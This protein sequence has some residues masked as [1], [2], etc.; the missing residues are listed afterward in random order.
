MNTDHD[1]FGAAIL[2]E[3]AA[4]SWYQWNPEPPVRTSATKG[5]L[6]MPTNNDST[7]IIIMAGV[8]SC[9]LATF[10][11]CTPWPDPQSPDVQA[12]QAAARHVLKL[13]DLELQPMPAK[14]APP[15]DLVT[16][17]PVLLWPPV[18]RLGR[19]ISTTLTEVYRENFYHVHENCVVPRPGDPTTGVLLESE[20]NLVLHEAYWNEESL[21][22]R[23]KFSIHHAPDERFWLNHS[24]VLPGEEIQ[25]VIDTATRARGND[26]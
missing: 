24:Q 14:P 3:L 8:H 25:R 15:S 1:P 7:N 18:D 20:D 4:S 26:P 23:M 22:W 2:E 21:Q 13:W 6:K 5:H 9:S 10:V 11:L 19:P 12:V 17:P 16:P